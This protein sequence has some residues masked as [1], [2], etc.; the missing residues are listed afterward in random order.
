MGDQNEV[1]EFVIQWE[2]IK[3]R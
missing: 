2:G 3:R 1:I